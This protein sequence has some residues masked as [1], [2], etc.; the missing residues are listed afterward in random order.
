[1]KTVLRFLAL[2]VNETGNDSDAARIQNHERIFYQKP[3]LNFAFSKIQ[4]EIFS[5]IPDAMK[6]CGVIV[7]LGAGATPIKRQFT[8]VVS[9]DVVLGEG[10]DLKLDAQ[11]MIFD[12][13]SVDVLICQNSFHHFSNPQKFFEETQR[14]LKREGRLI[15]L[16][17]YHGFLA[18]FLY[19]RL[20]ATEDFD[21][22]GGWNKETN[23]AMEDANQALSYIVF[24]RDRE[25]FL[26]KNK[27]LKIVDIYPSGTHLT[28]LVSG[29]L[30][31][32][33]VLPNWMNR[34]VMLLEKKIQFLNKIIAIHHFIVIKKI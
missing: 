25:L 21:I 26:E 11:E 13:D 9:S 27:N 8:Q 19:K 30:N 3:L 15:M 31:F 22:N 28:Y 34:L 1:M 2:P 23:D 18:S 14:V 33:Q 16:E 24:V 10:I 20:F 32:R 17:P 29:G 4:T 7:E 5:H 6:N 12:D